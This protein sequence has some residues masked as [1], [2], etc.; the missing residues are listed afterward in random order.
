VPNR[1]QIVS[2]RAGWEFPEKI[3]TPR[4]VE[5][6]KRKLGEEKSSEREK[7]TSGVG[8]HRPPYMGEGG[9]DG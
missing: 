8:S 5:V 9:I 7:F 6:K 2:A 3:W 4:I 1:A